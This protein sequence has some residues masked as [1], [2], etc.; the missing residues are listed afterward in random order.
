MPFLTLSEMD[1]FCRR[2]AQENPRTSYRVTGY[3]RLGNPIHLLSIAGMPESALFL[4]F[5]HPGEPLMSLVL[6]SL[7]EMAKARRQS[8]A[9]G[10]WLLVPI[11]DVD[12][13]R[14]NGEWWTAATSLVDVGFFVSHFF[15]PG[16][17]WQVEW[18]FP[19]HYNTYEFAE[20]LLETQAV[21]TIMD[22][23]HP[24]FLFSVHNALF[25][26]GYILLH[27]KL[28]SHAPRLSQLIAAHSGTR[29][30]NPI[31]YV[32]QWAPSVYGLPHLSRE[33]DFFREHKIP[34]PIDY[35]GAS[36]DYSHAQSV[37][38]E[39]PILKWPLNPCMWAD[40]AAQRLPSLWRQFYE[41]LE[42]AFRMVGLKKSGEV[43]RLVSN[44]YYFLERSQSDVA[45]NESRLA[46]ADPLQ[47]GKD[48]IESLLTMATHLMLLKRQYPHLPP[49]HQ[50]FLE[51]LLSIAPHFPLADLE[52]T[53]RCYMDIVQTVLPRRQD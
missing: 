4:G 48:Y 31:P 33:L 52:E 20:P 19:I 11:W 5:P 15:R 27:D 16:P 18:T 50:P 26:E 3:S 42:M 9:R 29:A 6:P 10:V 34:V 44:P 30:Y 23:Y 2:F 24:E 7:L 46:K 41:T 39:L 1:E 32:R 13:A 47:Q 45:L 12:G 51:E 28:A 36:F 43:P 22:R 49:S 14:W 40:R 38:A 37:V 53:Q 35:G 21:M 8:G 17:R 25:P